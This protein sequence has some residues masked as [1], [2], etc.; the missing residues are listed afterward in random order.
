MPVALVA[1]VVD[2]A[3]VYEIAHESLVSGW[4]TL[5]TWLAESW[6]TTALVNRL[7]LLRPGHCGEARIAFAYNGGYG[8]V[9]QRM[10]LIVELAVPD[11]GHGCQ[12]VA[13]A[14]AELSAID[15]PAE[16][17]LRLKALYEPLLRP[18]HLGQVRSNEFINPERSAPW[19]LREWHL[20]GGE[21]V[22]APAKQ[23]VD[24]RFSDSPELLAWVQASRD[25]I[26]AGTAEI[27]ERFLAAMVPVT[28]EHH[29]R[30]RSCLSRSDCNR[31]SRLG[32]NVKL[33]MSAGSSTMLDAPCM[34]VP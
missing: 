4:G 6:H 3:S 31:R 20:V 30:S 5:R 26:R 28:G 14:W 16:R 13:Q 24:E 17:L 27:P 18:E 21:L 34:K 12:Q 15:D 1:R 8:D 29:T 19:E 25:S 7:D 33:A 9:S 32:G 22:L 23:A 2:G 11:D 10:T